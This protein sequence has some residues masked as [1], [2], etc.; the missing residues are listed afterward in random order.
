VPVA[1]KVAQQVVNDQGDA[2]EPMTGPS[3][4]G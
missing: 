4:V 1:A 3:A 2:P